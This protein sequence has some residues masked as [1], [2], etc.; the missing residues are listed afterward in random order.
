[1][2]YLLHSA[3]RLSSL[4]FS[5]SVPSSSFFYSFVFFFSIDERRKCGSILSYTANVHRA[6]R[7]NLTLSSFFPRYI[8]YIFPSSFT[9]FEI[10]SSSFHPFLF[11][12][13]SY[14]RRSPRIR[15]RLVKR[16]VREAGGSWVAPVAIFLPYDDEVTMF[17]DRSSLPLGLVARNLYTC[18]L[19]C[20]YNASVCTDIN[21]EREAFSFFAGRKPI[22]PSLLAS[23]VFQTLAKRTYRIVYNHGN[24][25]AFVN[26]VRELRIREIIF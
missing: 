23:S 4:Y 24:I 7:T 19:V 2:L 8:L 21:L 16:N 6:T 22:D 11:S 20:V 14:V 13:W 12:S 1:M 3:R 10:S 9:R 17:K 5:S 18:M 25:N 15:D 26:H